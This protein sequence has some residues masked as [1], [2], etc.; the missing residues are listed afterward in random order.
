ML[1]IEYMGQKVHYIT[2]VTLYLTSSHSFQLFDN[3]IRLVIWYL[4]AIVYKLHMVLFDMKS[5]HV[6]SYIIY[7]Q[8][9]NIYIYIYIFFFL[10]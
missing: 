5:A 4:A 10:F 8:K 2:S 1:E 3:K 7:L 9:K 6:H